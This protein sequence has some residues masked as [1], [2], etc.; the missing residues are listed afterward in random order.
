MKTKL[1]PRP[2][3]DNQLLCFCPIMRAPLLRPPFFRHS[4]GPVI[5]VLLILS[6]EFY[7]IC[8]TVTLTSRQILNRIP[9]WNTSFQCCMLRP[10]FTNLHVVPVF[11]SFNKSHIFSP[12]LHTSSSFLVNSNTETMVLIVPFLSPNS[13]AN[14]YFGDSPYVTDGTRI[15][16][17]F[18]CLFSLFNPSSG[19]LGFSVH[20]TTPNS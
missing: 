16:Y 20:C 15:L 11:F 3:I 9:V 5:N 12:R 1:L 8:N 19:L 2:Y 10:A 4:D 17:P 14:S 7:F 6:A 13:L 18:T